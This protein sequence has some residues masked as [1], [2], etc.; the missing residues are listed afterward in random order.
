MAPFMNSSALCIFVWFPSGL[1]EST[2]LIILK[3]CAFPFLGGTNF[4]TLSVNNIN[5][6]LSLF[7][8]AEKARIALSSAATLCLVFDI[9]PNICE[10]LKSTRSITVS[11]RSSSN[12]FTN[13]C[14]NLA[15]TFQSIFRISSPNWYSRTS[16]NSIPLPLKTEWYSPENTWFTSPFVLISI[17]LTC[18]SS[19]LVSIAAPRSFRMEKVISSYY[20]I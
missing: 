9:D 16:E 5:P 19:S 1:N 3:T 10:P 6:T 12:I 13:G 2:S 8:N 18:L 14:P 17:C 11:S 20:K 4:S 7:F 15:V